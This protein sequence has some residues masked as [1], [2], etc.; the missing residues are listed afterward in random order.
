VETLLATGKP[1]REILRVATE[2]PATS[3]ASWSVDS[4]QSS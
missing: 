4:R 1:Y 2:Q 3:G